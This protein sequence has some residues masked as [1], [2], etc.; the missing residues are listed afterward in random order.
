[1]LFES[2]LPN[3]SLAL[4]VINGSILLSNFWSDKS[5]II[6]TPVHP[7]VYQKWVRIS[8]IQVENKTVRRY[9]FISYFSVANKGKRNVA[10]NQWRLHIKNR[11][12]IFQQIHKSQE[13][14]PFN[15]PEIEIPQNKEHSKIIRVWGQSTPNYSNSSA[16]I[17][18]GNSN[19][20]MSCW[21]YE[22]YGE[23]AWSPKISK[24]KYIKA[25]LKVKDVFGKYSNCT[26]YF[27]HISLESLQERMP[28]LGNSLKEL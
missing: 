9:A 19:L 15:I 21:I 26:L 24:K 23:K 12:S 16:M 27:A 22:V 20:G 10:I 2:I 3:A 5:K 11:L 28:S 13:L 7:N 8:D 14:L 18:S 1:M 4:S 6:V 25:K 17:E